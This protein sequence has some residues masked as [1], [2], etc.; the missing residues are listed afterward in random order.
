MEKNK[1]FSPNP[2]S[3]LMDQVGRCCVITT[4]HFE[5][6]SHIVIGFCGIFAFTAL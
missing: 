3:R 4:T 1:R 2:N 6:N 5:Q